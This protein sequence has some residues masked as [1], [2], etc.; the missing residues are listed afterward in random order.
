MPRGGPCSARSSRRCGFDSRSRSHFSP[1]RVMSRG[2]SQSWWGRAARP[3]PATQLRRAGGT[4]RGVGDPSY[5]RP[6]L[7]PA[8]SS[9][10]G[11][12]G[13]TAHGW[14]YGLAGGAA[15]PGG[16]GGGVGWGVRVVMGTRRPLAGWGGSWQPRLAALSAS[17]LTKHPGSGGGLAPRLDFPLYRAPLTVGPRRRECLTQTRGYGW[18]GSAQPSQF[19]RGREPRASFQPPGRMSAAGLPE[20]R[21]AVGA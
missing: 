17:A 10:L 15:L 16:W 8:D 9:P 13:G 12:C 4:T 3:G 2:S 19:R 21:G 11:H 14:Q 20:K 5:A 18:V 1:S 6:S 7:E